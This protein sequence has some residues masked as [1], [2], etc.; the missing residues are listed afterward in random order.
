M[1]AIEI[2]EPGGPEKLSSTQLPLIKPSKSHL[3]VKVAA[4][5]INRPDIF[6]RMGGIHHQRMHLQYQ[7]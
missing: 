7:D 4:A 1:L 2:I 6:Q 5:G 3:L